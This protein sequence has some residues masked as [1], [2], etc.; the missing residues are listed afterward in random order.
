MVSVW[1]KLKLVAVLPRCWKASMNKC[2]LSFCWKRVMLCICLQCSGSEFQSLTVYCMIS[3]IVFSFP[4][5]CFCLSVFVCLVT[6]RGPACLF[7]VSPLHHFVFRCLNI[8]TNHGSFVIMF[9]IES[10]RLPSVCVVPC[11]QIPHWTRSYWCRHWPGRVF[12]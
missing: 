4:F 9:D 5:C 10:H 2:V 11:H 12:S 8:W 1:K 6:T 3:T 7:R